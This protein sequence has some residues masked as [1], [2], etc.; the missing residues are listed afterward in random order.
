MCSWA[1][2][3]VNQSECL[4][5]RSSGAAPEQREDGLERLLHHPPLFDGIDAH[6]VGVRWQRAGSGTEHHPAAR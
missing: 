5:M 2:R 3:R 6:H 1:S 4:L